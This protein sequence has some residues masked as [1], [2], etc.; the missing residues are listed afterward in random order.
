M[1]KSFFGMKITSTFSTLI[2]SVWVYV[3]RHAE[4]TKNNKLQYL[5]ENVKDEVEF[6]SEGKHERFLQIDTIILD[7]CDQACPNYPK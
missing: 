5:E 6:L 4:S 2:L 1:I 3:T 7:V